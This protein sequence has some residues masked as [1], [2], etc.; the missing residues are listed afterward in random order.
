[1]AKRTQKGKRVNE[2]QEGGGRQAK[3]ATTHKPERTRLNDVYKRVIPIAQTE[4]K[5]RGEGGQEKDDSRV[6]EI[7]TQKK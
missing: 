3:S 5:A 6:F 2:R 1:M 7:H 4:A